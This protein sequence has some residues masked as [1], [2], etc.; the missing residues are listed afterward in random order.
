M[1]HATDEQYDIHQSQR[2]LRSSNSSRLVG[3]R[4]SDTSLAVLSASFVDAAALNLFTTLRVHRIPTETFVSNKTLMRFDPTIDRRT[5]IQKRL[6]DACTYDFFASL[7]QRFD[8]ASLSAFVRQ[9]F[10]P[11]VAKINF[12]KVYWKHCIHCRSWAIFS[13]A[14]GYWWMVHAANRL[15]INTIIKMI[16]TFY[17]ILTF[18]STRNNYHQSKAAIA[19]RLVVVRNINL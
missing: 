10:R 14:H 1:N 6:A 7:R 15:T 13:A 3:N 8:P 5:R 16:T 19:S 12:V 4:S 2:R 17:S 18:L 11:F 9:L